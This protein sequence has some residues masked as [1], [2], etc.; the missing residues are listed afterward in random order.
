MV[1]RLAYPDVARNAQ[2]SNASLPVAASTKDGAPVLA[3]AH[4]MPQDSDDAA[5]DLCDLRQRLDAE[6]AAVEH[7]RGV[8]FKGRGGRALN[9]PP[10]V[11][12]LQ[13]VERRITPVIKR[14]GSAQRRFRVGTEHLALVASACVGSIGGVL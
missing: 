11:C 12:A 2:A 4:P 14:A 7:W 8:A 3:H 13:A 6:R 9:R 10:A 5:V 1:V